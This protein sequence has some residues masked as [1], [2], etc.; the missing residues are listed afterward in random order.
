[1]QN[2]KVSV[3]RSTDDDLPRVATLFQEV[4]AGIPYYNRLSKRSESEKW[5][6]EV[7]RAKLRGDAYSIL[8][9]HDENEILGFAFT[10]FDDYLIWIEWFGVDPASRRSGV[11]SAL[12]QEV[13]RTAPERKAHKV[14]CDTRSNNTP[15]KSTFRKNGF[16]ELV[17]LKNHWYG[18]D[19]ILWERP[20]LRGKFNHRRA[21]SSV[22]D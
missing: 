9:A 8:V 13:V 7:L 19:Y 14:W 5:S 2:S 1:M 12:V 3:R 17:L 16:R 22:A 21:K 4:V 18:E 6:L 11:G 20:L 10:R 15:A